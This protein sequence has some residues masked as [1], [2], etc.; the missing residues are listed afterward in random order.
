MNK[1][2]MKYRETPNNAD[3]NLVFRENKTSEKIP[4]Q[5]NLSVVLTNFKIFDQDPHLIES[6]RIKSVKITIVL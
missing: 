1:I 6:L 5:Q 4:N 3:L 2:K